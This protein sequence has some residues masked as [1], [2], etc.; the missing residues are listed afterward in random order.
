VESRSKYH[1]HCM[2]WNNKI[3]ALFGLDVAFPFLDRDLIAFL[4]STPGEEQNRDGVP[5]ALLRE[6]MRGV[7]PEAIRRRSWKAGFATMAN[8]GI[9]RDLDHIA[10]TIT[11]DCAAVRFGFLRGEHLADDVA[12]LASGLGATDCIDAWALADM[13]GLEEWLEVF[14]GGTGSRTSAE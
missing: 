8:D 5:R 9:A 4:M 14:F 2:E 12:R 1:V 3:G 13:F 11:P 10:R 7:L 6:A